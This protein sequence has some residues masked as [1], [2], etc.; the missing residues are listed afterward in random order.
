[1]FT[2][3]TI[4]ELPESQRS[5]A[6]T[7]AERHGLRVGSIARLAVRGPDGLLF[8]WVEVIE[9]TERGYVGRVGGAMNSPDWLPYGTSVKFTAD[10]V[11]EV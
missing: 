7:H 8:P 9:R 10:C 3:L 4:A 5:L 2:I 11:V 1:M 6:A